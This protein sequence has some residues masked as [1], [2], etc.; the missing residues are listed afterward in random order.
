MM[1]PHPWEVHNVSMLQYTVQGMQV[2]P[3]MKI[4][5]N[6]WRQDLNWFPLNDHPFLGIH[7]SDVFGKSYF[8]ETPSIQVSSSF[9]A[10]FLWQSWSCAS[11]TF[12]FAWQHVHQRVA[13]WP[14]FLE[15]WTKIHAKVVSIIDVIGVCKDSIYRLLYSIWRVY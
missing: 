13:L 14:I 5:S 9:F 1:M 15:P 7:I 8:S 12:R 2:S 3:Y 10:G 4:L 6:K 11:W